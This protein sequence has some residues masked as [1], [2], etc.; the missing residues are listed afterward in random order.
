MTKTPYGYEIRPYNSLCPKVGSDDLVNMHIT[1][2][3]NRQNTARERSTTTP[4]ATLHHAIPNTPNTT[5]GAQPYIAHLGSYQG[6][7]YFITGPKAVV[8]STIPKGN[9]DLC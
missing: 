1:N 5:K 8:I 7:N 2:T 9:K 3:R 4:M 6:K